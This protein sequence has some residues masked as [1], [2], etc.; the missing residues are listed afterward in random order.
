MTAALFRT[1]LLYLLAIFAVRLMGKR[2]IGELEPSD[3]VITILISELA[4]I[5]MQDPAT[6]LLA[7]IIPIFTLVAVEILVSYACIKSRR[8]HRMVNG[9]SAIIIQNGKLDAKKIRQL[10]ISLDEVV[11]ELRVN[12][13]ASVAHV[14]Y[15]MI[16]PNGQ[17]S[18]VLYPQIQPLTAEMLDISPANTGVPLVVIAD[19]KAVPLSMKRLKLQ[20]EDLLKRLQKQKIARIADVLLM[21]LDDC[22][23]EF[24]QAKEE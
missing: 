4:T 21:T 7:G 8:L 15:G 9:Q 11:E 24:I 6:P 20:E 18:Y 10:R 17:L 23:N 5:P 3:L 13:I 19:G 2:Q 14:R 1:L 12:N 16:E 22:G